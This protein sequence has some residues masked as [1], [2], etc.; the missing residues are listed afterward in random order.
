[1]A[2]W[3][4]MTVTGNSQNGNYDLAPYFDKMIKAGYS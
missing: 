1:M 4:S 2:L 3:V